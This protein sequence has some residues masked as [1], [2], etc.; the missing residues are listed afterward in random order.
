MSF[1]CRTDQ[2]ELSEWYKWPFYLYC[3][4][5][6]FSSL[7][8]CFCILWFMNVLVHQ[9]IFLF[10]ITVIINKRVQFLFI[11]WNLNNLTK[12]FWNKYIGTKTYI[13]FALEKYY[14]WRGKSN[15]GTSSMTHRRI[16][17]INA[18]TYLCCP[19]SPGKRKPIKQ[20]S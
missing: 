16:S 18:S 6:R 15:C 1:V 2:T 7:N 11:F 8:S 14:V 10:L 4:F 13:L 20:R 5:S 17:N 9:P 19:V 12:L 3:L